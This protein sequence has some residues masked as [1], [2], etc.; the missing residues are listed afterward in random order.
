MIYFDNNATSL[1]KLEVLNEM[2]EIYNMPINPSSI[3]AYGR[4]GVKIIE[5]AK[6]YI[7]AAINA[8]KKKYNIIFTSS[9]TESN[10]LFINSV[11]SDLAVSAI[12]HVSILRPAEKKNAKIISVD[13][14]GMLNLD[15]LEE[16]CASSN[17][18][19]VSV[20]HANNETGVV[21]DLKRIA[22]IVRKYKGVIHSDMIQSVGKIPVDISDLD[23]DSFTISSHKIGGPQGI[24]ALFAKK[25]IDIKPMIIGGG[26]NNSLRSGTENVA[27]I[28]GM[29]VAIK[30]AVSKLE[31]YDAHC[32]KLI[33]YIKSSI[34]DFAK[35]AIFISGEK[36]ISNTLVAI[37][38]GVSNE[39]Q[40]IMFDSNNIALSAGSACSSGRISV[41]HVLLAYGFSEELAKN[42]IR[43]SV[44]SNNNMEEAERFI[45]IW[46][47]IYN[48]S[49]NGTKNE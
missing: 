34:S 43:I 40:L 31:E 12:D 16:F 11:N 17:K 32:R 23:L 27:G 45:E 1:I 6:K 20:I 41:S 4:G 14:N 8:D 36:T 13:R 49:N 33:E 24:S 28:Y 19:V 15:E 7:C 37:M 48:N 29:S 26:Q 44:S 39:S 46:K 38:P 22:A 42:A 9:G 25:N 47:K 10:N 5:D 2:I 18:P 30:L 3:H 35:D 21:Q